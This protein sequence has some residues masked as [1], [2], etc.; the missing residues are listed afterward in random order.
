M[1][2]VAS[3]SLTLTSVADLCIAIVTCQRCD[4]ITLPGDSLMYVMLTDHTDFGDVLD[5]RFECESLI[6]PQ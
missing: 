1:I 5:Y 3:A 2:N 4:Q 6:Y